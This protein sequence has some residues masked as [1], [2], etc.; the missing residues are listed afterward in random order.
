MFYL[1]EVEVGG[2]ALAP[3][4]ETHQF[5]NTA[6]TLVWAMLVIPVEEGPA[7]ITTTLRMITV[8]AETRT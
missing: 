5:L 3:L 4:E 2:Q 6:V 7:L 1:W 8:L